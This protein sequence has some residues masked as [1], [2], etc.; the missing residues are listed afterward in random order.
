LS[1]DGTM[2]DRPH[3]KQAQNVLAR[4]E[5]IAAASHLK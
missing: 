3:L 4:A 1:I 2:V 5:A